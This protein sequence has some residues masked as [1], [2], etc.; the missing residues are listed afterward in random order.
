MTTFM[1]LIVQL[2]ANRVARASRISQQTRNPHSG[3]GAKELL[4]PAGFL[5]FPLRCTLFRK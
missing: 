4:G 3:L 1:E 2:A 5:S